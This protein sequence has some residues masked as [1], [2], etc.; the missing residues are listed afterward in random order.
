MLKVSVLCSR[1]KHVPLNLAEKEVFNILEFPED[2]SKEKKSKGVINVCCVASCILGHYHKLPLGLQA[3]PFE[4]YME[5]PGSKTQV[6]K[7]YDS[8]KT[9]C[10][11]PTLDSL[12]NCQ[13]YLPATRIQLSGENTEQRDLDPYFFA[14]FPKPSI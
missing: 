11:M 10:V 6:N 3:L 7:Y 4:C 5:T 13:F 8:E 2:V 9:D 1:G 12:N 14:F